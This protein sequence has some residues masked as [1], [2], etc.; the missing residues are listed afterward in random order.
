MGN[1]PSDCRPEPWRPSDPV[2]P[3]LV[4]EDGGR[5]G[6]AVEQSGKQ[7]DAGAGGA[8]SLTGC[9]T[10]RSWPGPLIEEALAR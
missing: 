8:E 9:W 1:L 7:V 6:A 3:E 2:T 5:D 10:T 4:R